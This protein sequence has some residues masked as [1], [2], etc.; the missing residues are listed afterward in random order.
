MDRAV[1]KP[2]VV[3]DIPREWRIKSGFMFSG[4]LEGCRH[5]QDD[6]E[7]AARKIV[8]FD[9]RERKSL[10]D[11]WTKWSRGGFETTEGTR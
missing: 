11:Q 2:L 7:G 6:G 4:F 1:S 8:G 9:R 5:R 3:V 10:E